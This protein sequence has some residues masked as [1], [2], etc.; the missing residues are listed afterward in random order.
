VVTFVIEY[1]RPFAEP[2]RSLMMRFPQGDMTQV[3]DA[4]IDPDKIIFFTFTVWKD[5]AG[6]IIA[7]P[8]SAPMPPQGMSTGAPGSPP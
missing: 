7:P 4:R 1:A 3:A 8:G 5:A 6:Q 2:L